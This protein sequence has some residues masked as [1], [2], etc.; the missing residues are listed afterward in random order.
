MQYD[1]QSRYL[2][3]DYRSMHR[4]DY[5]SGYLSNKGQHKSLIKQAFHKWN[6]VQVFIAM[7]TA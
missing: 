3:W 7:A 5:W 4:I 2:D 6:V 1:E